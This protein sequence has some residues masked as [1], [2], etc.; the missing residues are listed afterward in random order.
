MDRQEFYDPLVVDE[1]HLARLQ[2]DV[3]SAQARLLADH[4]GEGIAW[5]LVLSEETPTP[6]LTLTLSAGAAYSAEGRR[7]E[8]PLAETVDLTEDHEGTATALSVAGM[9]RVLAVYLQPVRTQ[10]EAY[11]DPA[12]SPPT[13]YLRQREHHQ[14]LVV[15]G[16]E[17]SAG[18][19][20]PP[21]APAGAASVLLGRIVRAH[22]QTAFRSWQVLLA[23]VVRAVRAADLHADSV[24]RHLEVSP[25]DPPSMVL[26]VSGGN[27]QINGTHL[28]IAPGLSP[29]FVAPVS[30]PVIALLGV[31]P[32]GTFEV[33]YGVEAL[34]PVRPSTRGLLPVAWV[35]LEAGQTHLLDEEIQDA[36]PWLSADTA[37]IRTH[38]VVGTAAQTV[39]PLPFAYPQA[40]GAL[41]VTVDGVLLDA[42]EFTET[43]QV[44]ITLGAALAGGEVVVVRA[45]DV[46]PL[47]DDRSGLLV[48]G[49]VWVPALGELWVGDIRALVLGGRRLTRDTTG[50][51]G[52]ATA[53]PST[54][55]YLFAYEG[56]PAGPGAPAPILFTVSLIPPDA[57][58]IFR[59][60]GLTTHRYLAPLRTNSAGVDWPFRRI[61]REHVWLR[62]RIA[63]DTIVLAG[64][65]ALSDTVVSLAAWVPPHARLVRVFVSVETTDA[66]GEAWVAAAGYEQEHHIRVGGGTGAQYAEREITLEVNAT[67]EL[68]YRV[69]ATATIGIAVVSFA[70]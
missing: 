43:S 65:V 66:G 17:A 56:A 14:V 2:D 7:V 58:R 46:A 70:D 24:E 20:T 59:D 45:L 25:T 68:L 10:E 13:G 54:W 62:T 27:V 44:S 47:S 23:D 49:E 29:T 6:D 55:Y 8:V 31:T 37:A 69:S 39:V 33:R 67:Q 48:G 41:L 22:G 11:S 15:A 12:A 19:A 16:A 21:A 3:E 36:R 28:A 50:N 51:I 64:G 63:G 53:S 38:R 18:M 52:F 1:T 26:V 32:S 61:G 34:S 9:E 60:D 5:G 4:L 42:T 35:G 57:A 30:D 40:A